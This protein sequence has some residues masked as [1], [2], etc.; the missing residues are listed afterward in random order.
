[1]GVHQRCSLLLTIGNNRRRDPSKTCCLAKLLKMSNIEHFPDC[2]T[3]HDVAAKT[4]ELTLRQILSVPCPRCG[5]VAEEA[6]ELH[7]GALRTKPTTGIG[8]FPQPAIG[9]LTSVLRISP[10]WT[11]KILL[12]FVITAPVPGACFINELRR[13]RLQSCRSGP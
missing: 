3:L 10:R 8:N 5:A 4:R 13:A 6:C 7:T 12:D 1:M 2:G 11:A 9:S